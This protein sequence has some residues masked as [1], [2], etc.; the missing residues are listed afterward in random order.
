MFGFLCLLFDCYLFELFFSYLFLLINIHALICIHKLIYVCLYGD[1]WTHSQTHKKVVTKFVEYVPSSFFSLSRF[2]DSV[3]RF[4]F[5]CNLIM[6]P[7]L[8]HYLPPSSPF[9]LI[10]IYY[11]K[12]HD[13]ALTHRL[14]RSVKDTRYLISIYIVLLPS[15][16]ITLY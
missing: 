11:I 6:D 4:F 3:L 5:T 12:L 1:L 9:F 7:S 8:L 13:I 15:F 16:C 14:I 2:S 10:T